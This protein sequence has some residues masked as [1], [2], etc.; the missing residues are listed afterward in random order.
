MPKCTN[1]VLIIYQ[2]C[3]DYVSIITSLISAKKQPLKKIKT[4][5]NPILT[6][7]S[8]F[9]YPSSFCCSMKTTR[10]HNKD[11]RHDFHIRHIWQDNMLL[12]DLNKLQLY[13]SY[14]MTFFF[15]NGSMLV[16]HTG[17][18]IKHPSVRYNANLVAP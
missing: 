8:F 7:V 5:P 10:G 4:P 9:Y 18:F 13:F 3:P 2:L 1:Y 11:F 12:H 6:D 16:L 14:V 15:M 17:T